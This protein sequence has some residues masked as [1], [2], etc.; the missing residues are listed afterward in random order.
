MP[1]PDEFTDILVECSV[2]S[3]VDYQRVCVDA[4]GR[5]FRVK[6]HSDP[7]YPRQ[8]RG[9]VELWDGVKWHGVHY[10]DPMAHVDM[11]QRLNGYLPPQ[12]HPAVKQ[13]AARFGAALLRVALAVVGEST[14]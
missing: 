6:I 10:V 14:G 9:A 2:A 1:N 3:Y 5:R 4:R 13:E 12:R 8:S 7:S 11:W